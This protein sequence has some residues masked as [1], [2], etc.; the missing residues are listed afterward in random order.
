MN[1]KTLYKIS[2]GLYIVCSKKDT[3]FNGQ[4]ANTVF[5]VTAEPIQIAVCLNKQNLTHEFIQESKVFT[6]SILSKQTPMKFIGHFGFKSGKELDKFK[7]VNYKIGITGVPIVLENTIGYLEAEAVGSLDVGTHTI[8][9]GKIV[10]AEII[11]NEEP[12]TYEYYHKVKGGISPKTA[13][14]YLKEEAI[15][16]EVSEMQKYKCTVCDYVYDPEKGDPDS[17]IKP[18]TPF[19]ELPDTWVCPICGADKSAFEKED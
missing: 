1:P 11:K 9:I 4:I 19:E 18:G 10:E 2:Y 12:M 7:E 15:Q 14:T 6:V 3:K 13:P 8:F 5:Q 16:K 17:G